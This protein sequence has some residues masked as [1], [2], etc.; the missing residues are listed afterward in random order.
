MAT[1]LTSQEHTATAR[2][3][4]APISTKQSAEISNALRFHSTLFAKKYLE[5]VIGLNRAVPFVRST[6][7]MGHKA[8]MS[9]GRFPIKAA[10]EFLRLVKSVEAN[11]QAKGLN[12]GS[13]K[14]IKLVPNKASIPQGAGRQG[15]GTKRTHLEIQVEEGKAGSKKEVTLKKETPKSSSSASTSVHPAPASMK[16]ETP[17]PVAT[18]KPVVSTPITPANQHQDLS[19]AD[20]LKRVKEKAAQLEQQSKEKKSMDDVSG[21]YEELKKKGSLRGKVEAK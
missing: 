14:I 17:K 3:L 8:G 21:L 19:N 18:P 1:K 12:A 9:S 15:R 16:V 4:N 20:L 10:K 6:K 7:D 13:L 11:A 5:E 2:V